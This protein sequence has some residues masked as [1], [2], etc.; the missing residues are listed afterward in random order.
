MQQSCGTLSEIHLERRIKNERENIRKAIQ[1][2]FNKAV[3]ENKTA[4]LVPL[5][6][7]FGPVGVD[8][9]N[10]DVETAAQ[11]VVEAKSEKKR[12]KT[13]IGPITAVT[14]TTTTITTNEQERKAEEISG[15]SSVTTTST[16][17]LDEFDVANLPE[18]TLK[19]T[20]VR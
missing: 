6:S 20:K 2:A 10:T 14:S 19:I 1:E 8:M 17:E 18:T 12:R 16:Q 9:R 3:E 11:R 13:K 15:V 5:P 4:A 7:S